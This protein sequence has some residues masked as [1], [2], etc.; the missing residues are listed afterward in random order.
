[1]RKL[2]IA[3]V[4][5]VSSVAL[6]A[7]AL[8]QDPAPSVTMTAKVSPS[9]A[10]TKAKPRAASISVNIQNSKASKTTLD[11]LTVSLPKNIKISTKGLK[12]C[13]KSV[14][15][16]EGAS[17]CPSG[18]RA[19]T[20]TAHA[21]L[22]PRG[23][24]ST[25]TFKIQLFVGGPKLLLVALE[26]ASLPAL[27][28]VLDGKISKASGKYGQKLTVKITPELQQPVPGTYTALDDIQAKISLKRGKNSLISFTGCPS[29]KKHNFAANLAYVPNPT[30]PAATTAN[31][32]ATARCS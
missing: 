11:T 29:G 9:K 17:G 7:V 5:A 15:E 18:T 14:L 8:A 26:E 24:A 2:L 30:P 21:T 16:A 6:A 10:G 27:R 31:A 25:L 12:T 3:A 32:T 19:G 20:G 1:L 22:D 23:Q 13:K 28:P 4:V